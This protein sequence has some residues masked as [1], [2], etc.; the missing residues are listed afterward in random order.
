ETELAA[1]EDRRKNRIIHGDLQQKYDELNSEV[2]GFINEHRL[3]GARCDAEKV[4][5]AE[6]ALRISAGLEAERRQA[7]AH[8]YKLK[9]EYASGKLPEEL[10][11]FEGCSPEYAVA[12]AEKAK[13]RHAR[14]MATGPKY[15]L[16]II[17]ALLIAAGIVI[18]VMA[19]PTLPA[20]RFP[21]YVCFGAAV[22]TTVLGISGT[23]TNAK[24][25]REARE[26][27]AK[28]GCRSPEQFRDIARAYEHY[29][30][31]RDSFADE[32]RLGEEAVADIDDKLAFR[33]RSAKQY[34]YELGLGDDPLREVTL[35]LSALGELDR[36]KKKLSA[37]EG[38]L[39]V[40]IDPA[41]DSDSALRPA[42]EKLCAALRNCELALERKKGEQAAI[43]SA[44]EISTRLEAAKAELEKVTREYNAIVSARQLLAVCGEEFS[45][46]MTP[47]IASRAEE[48]FARL[49]N[50]R[51]GELQLTR[52][53]E[54]SAVPA[55][56]AVA[57]R[58]ISLSRGAMDQA[59]LAVR[60]ALSEALCTS[61]TVP[62]VLDDVL[63][64]YDDERAE[65]ALKFFGEASKNRQIILFTCRRRDALLTEK[66]GGNLISL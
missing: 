57:R 32:I 49:T 55:G 16:F 53:L 21:A 31:G 2:R 17:S 37:A 36:M 35:L 26:M 23:V 43:G 19:S 3:T 18:L 60:L 29:C 52:S 28:W 45:R 10:Q 62:L 8:V 65:T 64:M 54:A 15:W 42:H 44:D 58:L 34:I 7:E 1:S 12:A 40:Y 5:A 50:G 22:I 63:A 25:K 27:L 56:E 6:K 59:W 38:A 13:K 11:V 66:Y 30:R 24:N 33:R 47:K 14:L 48:I 20:I 61:E 9:A 39:I 46:E 4:A 51:Y 41:P